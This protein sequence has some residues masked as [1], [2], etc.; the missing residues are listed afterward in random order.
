MKL[1]IVFSM[2]LTASCV[3]AQTIDRPIASEEQLH[4]A[5]LSELDQSLQLTPVKVGTSIGIQKAG[6][7]SLAD[8][9]QG[10]WVVL[11]I[12]ATWCGYSMQE[13]V[14]FENQIVK[15]GLTNVKEVNITIDADAQKNPKRNQSDQITLDFINTVL[16]EKNLS[17]KQTDF[18]HLKNSTFKTLQETVFK[19]GAL[20]GA[21][22]GYPFQIIFNPSGEIVFAGHFTHQL[23]SDNGDWS[24]AYERHFSYIKSLVVSEEP[25]N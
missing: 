10:Q 8:Q 21:M 22:S 11:N 12:I 13:M 17:F 15:S 16:S 18:F 1:A 23:P 24:K 14:Y 3:T 19:S 25:K 2:L 4:G 5:L 9:Y 7:I 20:F 6:S